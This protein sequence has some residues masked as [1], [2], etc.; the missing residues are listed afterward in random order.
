MHI[1]EPFFATKTAGEYDVFA[2]VKGSGLTGQAGAIR[3]GISR[4]LDKLNADAFHIILRR[5]DYLTRDS[6]LCLQLNSKPLSQRPAMEGKS[7]ERLQESK[8][9]K[10]G[11]RPLQFWPQQQWQPYLLATPCTLQFFARSNLPLATPSCRC[12]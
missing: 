2:T 5:G 12:L 10:N 1:N 3:H 7:F 6:R 11:V 8:R 4:A 9:Q